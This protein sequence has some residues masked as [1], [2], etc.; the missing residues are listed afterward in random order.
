MRGFSLALLLGC[1]IGAWAQ[2]SPSSSPTQGTSSPANSQV[3]DAP[4]GVPK[5]SPAM[6]PPNQPPPRSDSVD[7]S[8]LSE[9]QGV[10]SSKDTQVD[11]SPP[12]GD[13]Q[14]HPRSSDV[15]TDAEAGGDVGEVH[16]WNPHKAAKDVE[17]GDFYFKRKNYRAAEDRYREALLYKDN[18]AMATFHLAECLE[19][20]SRPVEAREEY[21]SYLRILPH[22]P[23]AEK[24]QKAIE[25]L[26]EPSAQAKPAQ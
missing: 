7:A 15:L 1:C 23:E 8:A 5:P 10:S 14:A 9:E 26:K 25:R 18:D 2:S 20:L 4:A 22:G 12:A 11:L 6:P 19:K 13:D 17:V 21:E 24:A 16:P 3:P